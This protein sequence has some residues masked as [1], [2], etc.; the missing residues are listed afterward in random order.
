MS[1][2][3]LFFGSSSIITRFYAKVIIEVEVF[4]VVVGVVV[5]VEEVEEVVVVVVVIGEQMQ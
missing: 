4:I 1:A 5:E 3:M 2:E